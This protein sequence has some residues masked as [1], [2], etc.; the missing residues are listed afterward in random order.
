MEQFSQQMETLVANLPETLPSANEESSLGRRLSSALP[1]TQLL[2]SSSITVPQ[3]LTAKRDV[4]MTAARTKPAPRAPEQTFPLLGALGEI[5]LPTVL[6]SAGLLS[7]AEKANIFSK[8][9]K[10]KAFST[11]EKLAPL[12]DKL[13]LLQF[14]QGVVDSK[15]GDLTA[16]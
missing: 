10:A 13:G 1:R 2:R 7:G 12:V 5:Q 8:L 16:T 9:E 4:S 3:S 15:S 6:S 11:A 14:L